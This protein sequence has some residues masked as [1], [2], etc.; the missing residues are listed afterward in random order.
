MTDTSQGIL[1]R[2]AAAE[3]KCPSLRVSQVRFLPR[4]RTP[5]WA[6][7]RDRRKNYPGGLSHPLEQ[8]AGSLTS[9]L[10]YSDAEPSLMHAE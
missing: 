2:H 5:T 6:S 10:P 4:A 8:S 3:Y 1:G 7:L 9:F